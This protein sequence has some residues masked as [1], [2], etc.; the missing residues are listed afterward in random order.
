MRVLVFILA[1][2]FLPTPAAAQEAGGV[3]APSITKG[4]GDKCVADTDYMRRYHMKELTHQRDKTMQQGVRT[5]KFSLKECVACHATTD[6]DGQPVSINAPGEFCA[7]CHEYAAVKVDCFQCH[8]TKP[9]EG[10]Q[11]RRLTLFPMTAAAEP[12]TGQ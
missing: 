3:P 1:M 6:D 11:A 4:K 12:E 9:E 2:M 8:A 10:K 5:K 7:S